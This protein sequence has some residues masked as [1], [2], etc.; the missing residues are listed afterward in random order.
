MMTPAMND[1]SPTTT[2]QVTGMHCTNCARGIERQLRSIGIEEPSVDFSSGTVQVQLPSGVST[3]MV[4][5]A[6]E[7][8]GF[9]V[10]EPSNGSEISG[11]TP[12]PLRLE[13]AILCTV[14]LMA[15]MVLSWPLIHHPWFQLA[16]AIPVMAIGIQA[17]GMSALRSLRLGAA[18]MDVL[19]LGGSG[20]AFLYSLIGT[21][22]Q[23]GHD[24]QF[25]ETAATIITA[26]LLGNF[27]E[28]RA[29]AKTTSSVRE[30]SALHAKRALRITGRENSHVTTEEIDGN[31]VAVG[32]ELLVRQGDS[33][34]TDG[35]V[36]EGRA[37]LD[38][39]MVTGESVPVIRT[40]GDSV[41]GA[42]LVQ[43]GTFQM[44]ATAVGERTVLSHIIRLVRESAATK[45]RIQRLGD[46]VSAVFVPA[47]AVVALLTFSIS[48][49]ALETSLQTALM[50]AIAVLV[51]ACP[52]A[53]GLATPTAVVMGIG[54]AARAGILVKGGATLEELA[55]VEKVLFDKTGTLTNG[56]FVVERL[57]ILHG[58]EAQA[59]SLICSLEQHS[60]HPIARSLV[61]QLGDAPRL[62]LQQVEEQPGL[63]IRAFTQEGAKIELIRGEGPSSGAALTIDLKV[64]GLHTATV[65]LTD[66]VRP[67]AAAVVRTLNENG[68]TSAIVSG[69][70]EERSSR[71]A[72]LVGIREVYSRQSPEQKL[73]LLLKEE[74]SAPVAFVGD[75]INDSPTLARANV[76]ISLSDASHIAVQSSDV[77]LLGGRLELL[78]VALAVAKLTMRTIRQNLFWAF[79]YNI[80]M[81]PLAAV[82]YLTPMV[83]AF[84]MI[85]SDL[86][87]IGNSLRLRLLRVPEVRS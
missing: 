18:N 43:Q 60:N 51:V 42:T 4:H 41:V 57:E 65:V 36:I 79:F 25:Y 32:D 55:R 76:G 7:S 5:E 16:L 6:I 78:P 28:E 74:Q 12:V 2:L 75:G 81:I 47:V 86:I 50:R 66:S 19:I 64:N 30:L 1:P 11:P 37:S 77:I 20:A 54:K 22:F 23:L 31:A 67:R 85:G 48:L 58:D 71:L 45:P 34:P 56:R 83:A 49:F 35:I 87:V 53:M 68:I 72:E 9:A 69:D 3:R 24:Y 63:G 61:E 38:E 13:L 62:P 27:L 14:P 59:R 44:R 82:G 39:S 40:V 8:L 73:E 10:S 80:V 52:C 46:A 29:I 15:H 84:S 21:L 26:V 17:F 70:T 33:I